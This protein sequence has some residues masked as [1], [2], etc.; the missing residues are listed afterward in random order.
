MIH[1]LFFRN[2][3]RASD[4]LTTRETPMPIPYPEKTNVEV[5]VIVQRRFNENLHPET[6]EWLAQVIKAGLLRREQH[7]SRSIEVD[8]ENRSITI[9]IDE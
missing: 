5:L 4:T 7:I 6:L 8:I 3:V 2:Y 1:K 9:A